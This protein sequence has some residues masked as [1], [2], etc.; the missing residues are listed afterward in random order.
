MLTFL[1]ESSQQRKSFGRQIASFITSFAVQ[2]FILAALIIV[3]LMATDA[4]PTPQG[5]MTFL[6]AAPPPPPPPPPPPAPRRRPNAPK[7]VLSSTPKFVAPMDIPDDI[8][9]GDFGAPG[10]VEGGVP[11]GVL[12]GIVGGLPDAPV[13]EPVRGGGVA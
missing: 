5:I 4:L 6:A 10:G 9:F 1:V 12:G 8:G 3:P 7:P 13:A 2:L 11:G